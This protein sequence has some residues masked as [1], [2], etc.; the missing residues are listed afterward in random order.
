[1][2]I[3]ANMTSEIRNKDEEWALGEELAD[4][5]LYEIISVERERAKNTSIVTANV[6]LCLWPE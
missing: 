3:V 2:S 4:T 5:G 6:F 1:M